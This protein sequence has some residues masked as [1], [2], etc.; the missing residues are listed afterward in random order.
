MGIKRRDRPRKMHGGYVSKSD[1]E[2]YPGQPLYH[3]PPGLDDTTGGGM[4]RHHKHTGGAL[5][6]SGLMGYGVHHKKKVVHRKKK[7]ALLFDL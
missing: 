3:P 4:R 2:K 5:F 1:Q 7:H 6:Q